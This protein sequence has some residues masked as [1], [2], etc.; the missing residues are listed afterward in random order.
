MLKYLLTLLACMF[1]PLGSRPAPEAYPCKLGNNIIYNYFEVDRLPEFE[2]GN[3]NFLRF[4]RS[5]VIW[6]NFF[7][8]EG[9]IILSFVVE[10]NGT[11]SSLRVEKH[12]VE[13]LDKQC[14]DIIQSTSGRWKPGRIGNKK[15]RTKLIV[16]IDLKIGY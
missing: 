3:N 2:E 9:T 1:L 13:A 16:P 14:F 6:P 15:V 8:G 5:K 12:L 11:I 7:G 4:I 10:T